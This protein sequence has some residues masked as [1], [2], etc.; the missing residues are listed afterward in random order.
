M[1]TSQDEIRTAIRHAR[2]QRVAEGPEPGGT[3]F[4]ERLLALPQV[5]EARCI[6][7]YAALPGEPDVWEAIRALHGRGCRVLLP[8]VSGPRTLQWGRFDGDGSLAPGPWSILEPIDPTEQLLAEASVIVVPAIAV[9]ERSGARIG[10]GGG[11]F[12]T[13]LA[14]IPRAVDGGPLRVSACFDDEVIDGLPSN[15]WDACVDVVVTP[16]RVMSLG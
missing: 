5:A 12:D 8:R 6:A 7:A 1:R 14:P 11:Y 10:Y 15:P 3:I 16:T 13:A 4:S 2:A 9:D